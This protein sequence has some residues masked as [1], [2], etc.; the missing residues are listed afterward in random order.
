MERCSSVTGEI[1]ISGLPVTFHSA[2]MASIKVPFI[3]Y[4]QWTPLTLM[5]T[6]APQGRGG[7]GCAGVGAIELKWVFALLLPDTHTHTYR[8]SRDGG[9]LIKHG[10]TLIGQSAAQSCIV[11]QRADCLTQLSYTLHYRTHTPICLVSPFL[12]LS[13]SLSFYVSLSLSV[14]G[15]HCTEYTSLRLTY[16]W[17][18]SL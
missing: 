15:S 5:L 13:V 9:H 3:I 16:H 8:M 1:C 14:C 12:S 6:A 17:R 2:Q 18:S 7:G 4:S 10:H 11:G